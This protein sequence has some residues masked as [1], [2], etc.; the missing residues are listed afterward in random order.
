VPAANWDDDS[1]RLQANLAALLTQLAAEAPRRP[2]W[3][4]EDA[5]NWQRRTMAGLRA[6]DPSYVGAFRGEAGLEDVEVVIGEA[7]GVAA[8]QVA[9]ALA[10]FE[11]TLTAVVAWMDARY[12][13]ADALDADGLRA[14]I[15]LAAW[16]HARPRSPTCPV[17]A[18]G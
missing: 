10:A 18:P 17:P 14:V 5:R 4:V 3:S 11:G 13:D 15:D 7:Y 6:P 12:P 1:P 8:S 2:R 9:A 16:A